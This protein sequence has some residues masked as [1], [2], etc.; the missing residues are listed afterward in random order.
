MHVNIIREI[1]EWMT[2][3]IFR[4]SREQNRMN[5]DICRLMQINVINFI[6]GMCY[7][8]ETLGSKRNDYTSAEQD[9][10]ELINL[11]SSETFRG[12]H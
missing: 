1:S 6:D 9:F 11:F 3:K 10:R 12:L 7:R 4:F 8:V 2:R 5:S